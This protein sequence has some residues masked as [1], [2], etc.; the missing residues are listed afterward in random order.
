LSAKSARALDVFIVAGEASGDQLGAS[1]MRGL[2]RRLV[3]EIRFRGVGGPAMAAEGLASQFPMDDV[4]AVGFGSVMRKL[5]LI[6]RRIRETAAAVIAAPPDVLILIDSPDFNQRVAPRVRR[7]LPALPV[8]R[9]VAP[10]VWVWR[11]GR[12]RKLTPFVDHVLAL[13]PF[14]PEVLK[15]LGGPPATYV[16]HPLLER[17]ADLRPSPEERKSRAKGTPVLLVLP[18][19]R[20]LEIARLAGIFG[21]AIGRVTQ[22]RGAIRVVL[23]TLRAC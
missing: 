14:E 15:K 10:T 3:G 12:A 18:G 11:P 20:R 4:T 8:V 22:K 5:P 7:A 13:F 21:E 6:L 19:S 17:I 2:R 23:P 9:Y 16:G 1:L